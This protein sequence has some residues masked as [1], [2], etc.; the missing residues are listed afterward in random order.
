MS[1]PFVRL[2]EQH[3]PRLARET[4]REQELLL[5]A[6]RERGEV[7]GRRQLELAQVSVE[8]GAIEAR[9]ERRPRPQVIGGL[10]VRRLRVLGEHEHVAQEARRA[11]SPDRWPSA[12]TV[13][14]AANSNPEI[15]LSSVDLPAPLTPSNP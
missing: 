1:S 3:Q 12:R 7:A 15:S 8:R 10:H 13:P 4:E 5:L 11:R 6:V 2:V 9:I 14:R